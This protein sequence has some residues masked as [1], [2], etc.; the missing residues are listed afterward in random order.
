MMAQI[1]SKPQSMVPR[2]NT[3]LIEIGLL[4]T[5]AQSLRAT[6]ITTYFLCNRRGYIKVNSRFSLQNR[7]KA[8]GRSE[9]R[10]G[11]QGGQ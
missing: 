10:V 11:Q 7:N 9:N 6:K 5:P 2:V 3:A 1:S 4:P 8:R